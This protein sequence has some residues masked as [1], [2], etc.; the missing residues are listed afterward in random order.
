M[1]LSADTSHLPHINSHLPLVACN[2]LDSLPMLL[3]AVTRQLSLIACPP[4]FNAAFNSHIT[5]ASCVAICSSFVLDCLLLLSACLLYCS[6]HWRRCL[7]RRMRSADYNRLY[8]I[9]QQTNLHGE[10]TLHGKQTPLHGE[11]QLHGKQPLHMKQP[12]HGKQPFLRKPTPLY[13]KQTP[14]HGIQ[15]LRGRHGSMHGF[16]LQ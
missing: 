9:R 5:P 7:A 3:S 2:I 10:Q 14:S 15:P 13:G 8:Y 1:L 6:E 12:L 16:R 11:L 4:R